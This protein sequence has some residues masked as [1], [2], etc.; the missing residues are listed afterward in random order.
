M[1]TIG[2]SNPVVAPLE[3]TEQSAYGNG[4][5]CGKSIRIDVNPNYEESSDYNEINDF[6]EGQVFVYADVVLYTDSLPQSVDAIVFGRTVSDATVVSNANDKFRYVGFGFRVKEKTNNLKSYVA[7]WLH[8]VYFL[9]DS[10][11][12]DTTAEQITYGTAQ[13][14]GKAY[15]DGNGNWRTKERFETAEEAD[16]WLYQKAKIL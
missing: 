10:K 2:V 12:Y 14:K 13:I 16:E 5:R 9:E 6:D 15:P 1:A 4:I 8:K 11:T 7:V 3:Q